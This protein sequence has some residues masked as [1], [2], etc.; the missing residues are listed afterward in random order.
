[1]NIVA[2][3]LLLAAPVEPWYCGLLRAGI[4]TYG[5]AAALDF[6]RKRG[7]TAAQ[8]YQAKRACGI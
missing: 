4:A 1:L 8:F 6:A 3:V 2:L 5:T 7:Y